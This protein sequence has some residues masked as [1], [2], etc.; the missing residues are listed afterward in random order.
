MEQSFATILMLGLS[1]VL[2]LV[3][4]SC[5]RVRRSLVAV[6]YGAWMG[7]EFH[8]RGNLEFF[9]AAL[10][11]LSLFVAPL[12]ALALTAA[13]KLSLDR[14]LFRRNIHLLIKSLYIRHLTCVGMAACLLMLTCNYSLLLVMPFDGEWHFAGLSGSLSVVVV[15]F[16]CLALLLPRAFR[17]Y[18]NS[19]GLGL[20]RSI[21]SLYSVAATMLC[22]N[23]FLPLLAGTS[24]VAVSSTQLRE[25]GKL[26]LGSGKWAIHAA[27][28][29]SVTLLSP[30]AGLA[31]ALCVA[32]LSADTLLLSIVVVFFLLAC[33]LMRLYF[34]QYRKHKIAEN[35]LREERSRKLKADDEVNRLDV[36][37]VTSQF[38]A[39][40]DEIDL[41]QR[42][43]VNLSLYI[44]QQRDYI[45]DMCSRMRS[46][47]GEDD[48][49]K[50]R[51]EV[52]AMVRD[53]TE[54]NRLLDEMNQFYTEV[55]DIHKNF[56]A[57]LCMRCPGITE[58][59]RRLAILLRLGFSTKEIAMLTNREPKSVE[60]G[61]YRFR[62][63][64]RL[65]RSASLVQY[66]QLL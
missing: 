44:K 35:L 55:E 65:D 18:R 47:A 49:D 61:R 33:L 45:E 54:N 32:T 20:A 23:V 22:F 12:V 8:C 36:V 51:E 14:W 30:L 56:V 52:K 24:A 39:I 7:L 31:A 2:S 26:Y 53:M 10:V 40:S 66:L 59:E 29:V 3:L 19:K 16:A 48:A 63:K 50:L 9:P 6:F 57:R 15:S 60:I 21:P 34:N 43:L 13:F 41:K 37:A 11:L 62:K 64:L 5:F 46:L 25:C 42:S 4:L 58:Q 28:L 27:N 17:A 1:L 38:N